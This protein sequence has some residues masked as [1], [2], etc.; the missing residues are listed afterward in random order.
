MNKYLFGVIVSKKICSIAS[1]TE[2]TINADGEC[3]YQVLY[4]DG[5][6]ATV[7]QHDC[8]P[9]PIGGRT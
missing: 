2:I 9:M 1:V 5:E 3:Y 8:K 6:T 7:S 4:P